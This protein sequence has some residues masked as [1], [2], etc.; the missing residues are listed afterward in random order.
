MSFTEHS[1]NGQYFITSDKIPFRHCFTG[2]LGGVGESPY[3]SEPT[4]EWLAEDT[5]KRV[6]AQWLN[7]CAGVGLP[8][9]LCFTH[10]VHGS[11]VRLASESDRALPPLAEVPADCDG[12]CTAQRGLPVVVFTADCVPVLLCDPEAPAAAALHCGWKGTVK[13]M[14]GAGVASLEALGGRAE[15]IRAAIGPAIS[16]CCFETG[17]EVPE[18]MERLLGN[19]AAGIYAPEEGHP[20]KFMVDLKEANRRRL[21]QLGVKPENIDVS[22]DCT[23]CLPNRYWSHRHTRGVRGTQAAIIQL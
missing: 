16:R 7:L 4:P 18:A 3:M 19:D 23:K 1:Y 2:Q 21:V 14:I 17:P 15:N 10:Q 6:R 8:T 5:Q 9:G 12:L 22:S 13:D 20:G 11:L